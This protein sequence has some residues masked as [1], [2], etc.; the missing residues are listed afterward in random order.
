MDPTSQLIKI[1]K[2]HS[3]EQ[4][5]QCEKVIPGNATLQGVTNQEDPR[6]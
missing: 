1:V 3:Q 2:W 4:V 5:T 6:T